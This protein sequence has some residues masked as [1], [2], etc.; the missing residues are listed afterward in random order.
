MHMKILYF[1]TLVTIFIMISEPYASAKNIEKGYQYQVDSNEVIDYS[2]NNHKENSLSNNLVDYSIFKYEKQDILDAI[3]NPITNKL[4]KSI[5]RESLYSYS[6]RYYTNYT[7][8]SSD[9]LVAS[10]Y[11]YATKEFSLKNMNI[12]SITAYDMVIGNGVYSIYNYI[13]SSLVG[14]AT[15]NI[16]DFKVFSG[17]NLMNIYGIQAIIKP[18]KNLHISYTYLSDDI[19]KKS[20]INLKYNYNQVDNIAFKVV[21]DNSNPTSNITFGFE[22][23]F[24]F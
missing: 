10:K 11:A 5:K 9:Y 22:W 4:R 19:Y 8:Y 7:D 13:L 23:Q 16:A 20:L 24:F 2:I 14:L 3:D 15:R 21:N 17:T 18:I 6:L 1:V 12:F